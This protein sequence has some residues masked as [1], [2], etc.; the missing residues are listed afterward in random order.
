MRSYGE[1]DGDELSSPGPVCY[2]P[3]NVSL[4]DSVNSQAGPPQQPKGFY[5]IQHSDSALFYP[6]DNLSDTSSFRK[7][8]F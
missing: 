7:W 5:F 6:G 4:Q 2:A 1:E 8:M 3:C